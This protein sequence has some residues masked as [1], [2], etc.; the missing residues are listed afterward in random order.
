M[1]FC[2][3]FVPTIFSCILISCIGQGS[4]SS[5]LDEIIYS[6][7]DDSLEGQSLKILQANCIS[8]HTGWSSY[9][10][11][12][13]YIDNGLITAGDSTSSSIITS[14]KNEGGTMPQNSTLSSSDYYILKD[15]VDNL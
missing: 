2:K 1:S 3:F 10:S 14:L 12:Q 9:T 4:S 7:G 13:D 5:S 6:E 8:C 11:S 15:W